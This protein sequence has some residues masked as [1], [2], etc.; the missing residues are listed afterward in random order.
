MWRPG[1]G[2]R[3][4]RG[5]AGGVRR[6]GGPARPCGGGGGLLGAVG[7]GGGPRGKRGGSWLPRGPGGW[8]GGG[9]S[10]R[11]CV[12]R[13]RGRRCGTCT[14]PGITASGRRGICFRRCCGR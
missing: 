14:A 3:S 5:V 1:W 9:S 12:P 2:G 10:R 13:S 8:G 11:N 6:G 7:G 4:G